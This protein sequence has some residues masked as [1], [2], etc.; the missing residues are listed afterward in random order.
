MML[1]PGNQRIFLFEGGHPKD[2]FAANPIGA[3]EGMLRGV[4]ESVFGLSRDKSKDNTLRK[5]LELKPL[6]EPKDGTP[7][8]F[9]TQFLGEY[10]AWCHGLANEACWC[11]DEAHAEANQKSPLD[12]LAQF[13]RGAI[14]ILA[15][16]GL[17][18]VPAYFALTSSWNPLA[19]RP[20]LPKFEAPPSQF[21]KPP[22]S[23]APQ[24]AKV[25]PPKPAPTPE[26]VP[27]SYP[28]IGNNTPTVAPTKAPP[29]IAAPVIAAPKVA[30]PKLLPPPMFHVAFFEAKANLTREAM[31]ALSAAA[32][33]SIQQNRTVNV[34][35]VAL[36]A[37]ETDDE[38]WR[39]RLYAVKD[40]L[41]RLGVPANRIRQEGAGPFMLTIRSN[42]P[43][44]PS[45]RR[46][47]LTYDID[48]VPD[49]MMAD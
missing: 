36:G 11:C 49:P 21:S 1:S 34:R 27:Q 5:A 47:R 18:A 2:G 24:P 22:E 6:V 41:V 19:D 31:T 4:G 44:L 8:K 37:R 39:R 23:I 28:G 30:P 40:E 38:L 43:A 48:S 26:R 9:E 14:V 7:E 25:E 45:S 15:I 29:K 12:L 32:G 33:Q 17:I 3:I 20:T 42:Q 35:V 10:S 13:L 46:Q 16:L